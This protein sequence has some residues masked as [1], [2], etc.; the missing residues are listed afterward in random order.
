M[1]HAYKSGTAFDW[2]G[3]GNH[4]VVSNM[5]FTGNGIKSIASNGHVLVSDDPSI[6]LTAGYLGVLGVYEN[7]DSANRLVYKREQ[8]V[9]ANYDFFFDA[10]NVSLYDGVGTRS[11]AYNVIGDKYLAT[12]IENAVVPK[13]LANANEIG[14]AGASATITEDTSDLYIGNNNVLVTP[15]LG[16]ISDVVILSRTLTA[17]EFIDTSQRARPSGWLQ[18]DPRKRTD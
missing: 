10:S 12:N 3:N 8:G 16:A 9:S 14:S 17:T 2:S 6:R 1:W 15:M 4:G 5:I 7:N 11:F 13:F 18:Y